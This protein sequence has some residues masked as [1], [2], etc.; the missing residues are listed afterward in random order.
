MHCRVE[1][2]ARQ[3]DNDHNED[4]TRVCVCVCVCA[5]DDYTYNAHL[6]QLRTLAAL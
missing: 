2:T 4:P 5:C 6:P 1:H 3:T